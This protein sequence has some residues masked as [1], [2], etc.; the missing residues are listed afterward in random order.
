MG[1]AERN[2]VVPMGRVGFTRA[3]VHDI[4]NLEEEAL[5]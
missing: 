1:Y 5:E 4:Q 3:S 2:G